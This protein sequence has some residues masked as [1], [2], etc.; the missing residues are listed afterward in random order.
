MKNR[1][2]PKSIP[3]PGETLREKLDELEMGPK[4]FAVR[5]GKPE[6]TITAVLNGESSITPDMAVKFEI[7]TRIPAHF[8][9]NHQSGFDEHIAR[10][11]QK[12]VIQE[13]VPWAQSFPITEMCQMGWLPD[14]KTEFD[15]AAALLTFFGFAEHHAW[16]DY[17]FKQ[18]LKVA[19]RI[20]LANTAEPFALSAWLRRGE[21][22]AAELQAGSY[23]EKSF[24]G[25]LPVLRELMFNQPSGF[26]EK[27]QGICLS[28]GVKVVHT[29]PLSNSAIVGSTRWILETPLIQLSI[30]GI[31]DP[32]FWFTFFHEA[33]HILLHRKKDIFLEKVPYAEMDEKKEREADEF[34]KKWVTQ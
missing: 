18:Q 20:S 14:S 26:F 7:V 24:K 31:S 4:E 23:S 17:Y 19:F 33:G 30:A 8:W 9:M 32:G 21:L 12:K 5:T 6:K 28:A 34:A 11:K 15:I 27:L 10:E 29:P 25:V 2:T 1:Y 16:E 3:H 22:Q 13:A